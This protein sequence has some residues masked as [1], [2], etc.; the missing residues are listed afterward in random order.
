M[1]ALF[2]SWLT[3]AALATSFVIVLV[4]VLDRRG[5]GPSDSE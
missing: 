2:V 4:L 5:D 1:P 3:M